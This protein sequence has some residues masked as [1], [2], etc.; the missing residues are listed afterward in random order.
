MANNMTDSCTTNFKI[1]GENRGIY[2]DETNRCVI[3]LANHECL[4]DVY[5]TITH[6]VV[7][8]CLAKLNISDDID[9]EQEENM[10]FFLAWADDSI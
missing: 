4:A 9:E 1:Y 7:H 2:Y 10:I 3:Y 5:R 8:H 6:E